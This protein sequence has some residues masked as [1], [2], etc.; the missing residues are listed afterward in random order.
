MPAAELSWRQPRQ[1]NTFRQVGLGGDE[2]AGGLPIH[3][4]ALR[5]KGR[6]MHSPGAGR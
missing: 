2:E 6:V 3:V 5:G 1:W 4:V